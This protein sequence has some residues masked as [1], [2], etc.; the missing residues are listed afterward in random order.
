MEMSITCMHGCYRPGPLDSLFLF[1]LW[2]LTELLLFFFFFLKKALKE[3]CFFLEEFS[4]ETPPDYK[5][6]H[7]SV[8]QVKPAVI[9]FSFKLM[10]VT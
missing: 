3:L 9:A 2:A 4:G 10:L 5:F 8:S 7:T 6:G 1:V